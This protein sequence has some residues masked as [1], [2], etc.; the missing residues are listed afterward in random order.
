M[1]FI[2]LKTVNII[3]LLFMVVIILLTYTTVF[4]QFAPT[5]PIQPWQ[6]ADNY[7]PPTPPTQGKSL[8]QYYNG[9]VPH[10]YHRSYRRSTYKHPT[11]LPQYNLNP[12]YNPYYTP[13][14]T[15][16]YGIGNNGFY[17]YYNIR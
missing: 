1:T 6:Y 7:R 10:S 12:Y 13:Y 4:G 16:H 9:Y 14:R 11:Y 2:Q 8:Q 17:W 3:L 5:S 15:F